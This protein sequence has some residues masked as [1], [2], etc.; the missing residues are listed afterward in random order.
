MA[1]AKLIRVAVVGATGYSGAE[2]VR[3]LSRHPHV[4]LTVVTSEQAAGAAL[5]SVHRTL[6]FTGLSLEAVDAAAIAPRC[7]FAFTALP[8]GASTPVVAELVSRGVRVIDVG[9]DFRFHDVALYEKWYGTH[10][11]PQL[12]A[13]AV[14]GLTEFTREQVA[15]ARLVANPGCYPTSALMGLIPLARHIRG[16]VF[17]DSKSG[18]SGAGRGAKVDQLFA[19][20]TE[21]IRP[22]SVGRHRHQPEIASQLTEHAGEKRTVVFSPHLLPVA[23][24]LQSTMYVDVAADVDVGALMHARYDGEPFV[25]LLEGGA[26][27]EPRAV[28]GTNMIEIAWTR[29]P[30][31]GCVVVLTAIDNLGKGAAGQAVQN[32]NCMLGVAETKGL[33]LLPALP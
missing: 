17:V 15:G 24:G 5:G 12:A 20:V 32:M 10:E 21:N 28:R 9:A 8:H 30:E 1:D 25:R 14:Y 6:A 13:Q 29:E 11:A 7:D 27:P 16:P 4:Q 19:E 2:L 18:T 33:D 26:M 31:S 3:L 22:Y 23:R